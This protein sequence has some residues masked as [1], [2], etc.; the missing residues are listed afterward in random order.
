MV[1][2]ATYICVY[3]NEKHYAVDGAVLG[4]A[5]TYLILLAGLFQW[6]VRQSS[7]VE[8][9]MVS[10][11]RV[12]KFCD[13]EQE[14][15]LLSQQRFRPPSDWPSSGRLQA[16]NLSAAY[17]E[18]KPPI[19]KNVSFEISGGE[20]VGVVGRTGAGKSS[21]VNT[22][23]RLIEPLRKQSLYLDGRDVTEIG[24]HDL[25]H[26]MAIIPQVPFLFSG[27]IRQ[28]LDPFDKIKAGEGDEKLWKALETVRL[29]QTVKDL[30]GGL[31]SLVSDRGGFSVGQRQLFCM[32]RALVTEAKVIVMDEATANVDLDTDAIIQRALRTQFKDSTVIMIAHRLQTVIDCNKI[33]VLSQGKMVEFGSPHELLSL[34]GAISNPH[35]FASMVQESGAGTSRLLK[36]QAREYHS[37][38]VQQAKDKD[39]EQ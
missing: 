17:E 19:L 34:P 26:R 15:P 6:T 3:I 27:T 39:G 28:N 22:L 7:E 2:A 14:A 4:A 21:L 16:I 20:K 25:R 35:S 13:N 9:Q 12:L 33:I 8:N 32:A 30:P 29:A 23:F 36:K 31:E 24:L 5:L 37:Q 38:Y 11:E 1:G 10:V 18:G